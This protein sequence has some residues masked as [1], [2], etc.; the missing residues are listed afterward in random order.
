MKTYSVTPIGKVKV[1]A[2]RV[3]LVLDEVFI[4]ALTQ[5]AGFSHIQVLWWF[6]KSD[7]VASRTKYL[8]QS[9]YRQAPPVMGV[10]ATRS[11]ERPNPIALSCV[12]ITQLHREDGV[13]DLAYID[14]ADGSPVLDIKPYTP[15]L[16]RVEAPAVPA[17][18]AHWPHSVEM[19]GSFAWSKEF[20]F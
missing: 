7:T 11:P 15:S 17:W 6:D 3:Q 18:C 8:E 4:P 12:R 1:Q 10:F 19:A 16:D 13:I 5:L 20:N 9:P 14:A 2:E